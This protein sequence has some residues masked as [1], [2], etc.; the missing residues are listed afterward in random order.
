MKKTFIPALLAVATAFLHVSCGGTNA[1]APESAEVLDTL[2]ATSPDTIV[3]EH[4]YIVKVGDTA[5]DFSLP[6]TDG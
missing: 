6:M 2:N 1:N 3:Y 4:D 5:P